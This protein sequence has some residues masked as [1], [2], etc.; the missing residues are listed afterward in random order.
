MVE[1]PV[2]AASKSSKSAGSFGRSERRKPV[3]LTDVSSSAEE[4]I[5]LGSAEVDRLL[6]G[7]IV[8]GSLV[9]IGGEPGIGKSTLSLQIPLHVYIKYAIL[10]QPL[11]H[12]LYN[13]V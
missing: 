5:S 11:N 2:Q 1:A 9:L 10:K 7:G 12:I 6:G 8:P 13:R 4:R 3:K